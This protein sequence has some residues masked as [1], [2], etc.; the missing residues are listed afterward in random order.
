MESVTFNLA[1]DERF[2]RITELFSAI[3]AAKVTGDFRDDSYWE[4]FLDER[5]RGAFWWP[6][7]AEAQDW[8]RRWFATPLEKRADDPSLRTPWM[9]GSLVDTARTGE[10]A[11][12]ACRR[13][14]VT[15]G[16]V[17]IEPVAWPFGGTDWVHA[18]IE[19]FGGE[20]TG[21]TAG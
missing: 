7:E 10:F 14:G 19:A 1:D 6:T 13:T 15:S 21:D 11:R 5:S 9:Y 12:L 3:A 16:A 18:L 20:I 2:L 4:A 8:Q 17:E